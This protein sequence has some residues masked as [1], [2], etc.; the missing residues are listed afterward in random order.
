MARM[1][2]RDCRKGQRKKASRSDGHDKQIRGIRKD[3]KD[4]VAAEASTVPASQ[5]IVSALDLMRA[6][7]ASSLVATRSAI[8][9][10]DSA[11][12][13]AVASGER[14]ATDVCADEKEAVR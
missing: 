4:Q 7:V 14:D 12:T 2:R 9:A 8:A 6:E 13:V 11:S 1:A 3:K 5:K 10:S